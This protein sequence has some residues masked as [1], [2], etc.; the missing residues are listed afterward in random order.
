MVAMIRTQRAYEI[1]SKVVSAADEM[2]DAREPVR[3]A[4][5]L[6]RRAAHGLGRA[7]SPG[8]VEDTLVAARR[9]WGRRATPPRVVVVRDAVHLGDL[10]PDADARRC[11]GR[12]RPSR[13][14]RAARA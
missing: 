13:P 11:A 4:S 10:M 9:A 2:L 1:N 12:P 8:R 7:R 14:P 3:L 6:A 5:P